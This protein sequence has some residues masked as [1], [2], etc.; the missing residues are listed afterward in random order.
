MQ[1]TTK[2]RL[3]FKTFPKLLNRLCS[4]SVSRVITKSDIEKYGELTGDKNPIHFNGDQS[5]VHGTFLLG[6][7]SSVM[8]TKCPGPGTKVLEL[9]S[10]FAKPC[11]IDTEVTVEVK[12]L[13]KRKITTAQYK[14]INVKN[15]DILVHGTAKLMLH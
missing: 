15:Q 10:K 14:V 6:L 5:I 7:V 3:K 2:M 11:T 4:T 1:T 12:L 13:E 9:T 8:G